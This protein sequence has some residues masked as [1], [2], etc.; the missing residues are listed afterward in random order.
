VKAPPLKPWKPRQ[1]NSNPLSRALR[2]ALQQDQFP[3][4][5][6]VARD[7]MLRSRL[8]SSAASAV[9]LGMSHA[10]YKRLYSLAKE[11]K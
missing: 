1:D 10:T 6:K 8:H 3:E 4:L 11:L 2:G 7:I 5:K 9:S